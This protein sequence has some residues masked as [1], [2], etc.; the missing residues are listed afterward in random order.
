MRLPPAAV[1]PTPSR[2]L[3]QSGQTPL[4]AAAE[5]TRLD[6]MER[7]LAAKADLEAKDGVR[8][9]SARESA[10]EVAMAAALR[11]PMPLAA[12]TRTCSHRRC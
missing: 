3:P 11:L 6:A 1:T 7:L 9:V 10:G 2:S 12:S 8:D 5:L 4:W